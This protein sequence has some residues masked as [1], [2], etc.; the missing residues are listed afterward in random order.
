MFEEDLPIFVET[1]EF[2]QEVEIDGVKMP[3]QLMGQSKAR[4]ELV[5]N[6]FDK[7]EGDFSELFFRADDYRATKKRLPR[8]GEWVY[9]NGKRYD[10]IS[11]EDEL[12]MAHLVLAAYRQPVLR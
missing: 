9:V 6:T 2:A 8:Q 11:S 1:A 7:L 10:V 5:R 4:S 12:G 3:A